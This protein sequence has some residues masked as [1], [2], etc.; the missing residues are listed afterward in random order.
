MTSSSNRTT[1]KQMSCFTVYRFVQIFNLRPLFCIKVYKKLSA[2]DALLPW[3]PQGL[4]SWTPLGTPARYDLLV[5]SDL[6][7]L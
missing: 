1:G 4:C 2:S 3:P 6:T 5:R 7:Q